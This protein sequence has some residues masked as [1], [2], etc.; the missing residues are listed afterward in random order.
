MPAEMTRTSY[1]NQMN[2][3]ITT[4]RDQT[5]FFIYT[6]NERTFA[7]PPRCKPESNLFANGPLIANIPDAAQA[8]GSPQVTENISNEA[9]VILEGDSPP[10]FKI[11]EVTGEIP[12][13]EINVPVE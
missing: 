12:T 3:V 8:N 1:A 6:A 9:T 7:P 4:T 11:T 5:A 10:N 13:E 2:P